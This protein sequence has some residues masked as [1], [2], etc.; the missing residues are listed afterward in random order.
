MPASIAPKNQL[1]RSSMRK[2]RT[3]IIAR[4]EVK[5]RS[6][7]ELGRGKATKFGG[8]LDCD[9]AAG[10]G[11]RSGLA[12]GYNP[13]RRLPQCLFLPKD[14]PRMKGKNF[15]PLRSLNPDTYYVSARWAYSSL[16]CIKERKRHDSI[17][18]YEG[19]F[20][21]LITAS[22]GNRVVAWAVDYGPDSGFA[23]VDLS[24]AAH[25]ERGLNIRGRDRI[26]SIEYILNEKVVLGPVKGKARFLEM[27]MAE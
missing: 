5:G 26:V 24:D 14:D 21:V 1:L 15:G 4:P 6:M 25:D 9:G 3:L 13:K 27:E 8:P 20:A 2:A 23:D 16:K 10:T 17:K 19:G 18:A 11:T 7:P 12:L 22:N